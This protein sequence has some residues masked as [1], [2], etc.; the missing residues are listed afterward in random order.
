MKK[1][2]F[3]TGSIVRDKR[4]KKQYSVRGH[5]RAIDGIVYFLFCN[6]TNTIVQIENNNLVL[7]KEQL[8][9]KH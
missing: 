8:Y 7:I 4:D 2:V 9:E 6:S 1:D 3:K 5:I